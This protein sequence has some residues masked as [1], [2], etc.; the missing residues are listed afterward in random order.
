LK[1]IKEDNMRANKLVFKKVFFSKIAILGI[2]L[3]FIIGLLLYFLGM[4][5]ITT[6][7][8]DNF[9]QKTNHYIHKINNKKEN[10]ETILSSTN[11]FISL[12][13]DL[14]VKNFHSYYHELNKQNI[15]QTSALGY[16]IWVNHN[17]QE[18]IYQKM[19]ADYEKNYQ[20]NP[21]LLKKILNAIE[22]NKQKNIHKKYFM[23]YDIEPINLYYNQIG[24]EESQQSSKDILMIV[25][26][27]Y[28]HRKYN[29]YRLNMMIDLPS[30]FKE[31]V[32]KGDTNMHIDYSI[33]Q[34]F[35]GKKINDKTYEKNDLLSFDNNKIYIHFQENFKK[36]IIHIEKKLMMD[37]FFVALSFYILWLFLTTLLTFQNKVN[38]VAQKMNEELNMIAW[39]D[40]LTSLYNR[41]YL[42][43]LIR[44]KIKTKKSK[45][46]ILFIDLDGFKKINDTLGHEA[47]DQVLRDYAKKLKNN[48]KNYSN[49][50]LGRVGGDEFIVLIEHEN[51]EPVLFLPSVINKITEVTQQ[52]FYVKNNK[53]KISQSIGISFYPEHAKTEEELLRK[54]DLAMYHNKKDKVSNYVVY[55]KQL[56]NDLVEKTEIESE[57]MGALEKNEIF[58]VMQPKMKIVNNKDMVVSGFEILLRWKNDKKDYISPEKFIKIAEENGFIYELTYWMIEK[59]CKIIQELKEEDYKLHFSINLSAQQFLNEELAFNII[60]IILK[61]N[62]SPKQI[63]FEITERTLMKN[64]EL[65]VSIMNQFIQNG[66]QFSIDDFGIGY[67][68]LSYL[69]KLPVSELKIDKSFIWSAQNNRNSIAVIKTIIAMGHQLRLKVVAEGVETHEQFTFLRQQDCDE[70]QGFYFSK[71]LNCQEFKE[72]L[73]N[74]KIEKNKSLLE[75][76]KK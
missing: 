44:L 65:S 57:L 73:K 72:F 13:N 5:K 30:F 7:I 12:I 18:F 53:F 55:S 68:S 40:N 24:A 34:E 19:M 25:N 29:I 71:P 54:S 64:P 46:S 41:A 22:K 31:I 15:I 66:F 45:F 14:N 27:Q 4:I 76:L 23:V 26:K 39:Y 21:I 20:D 74:H 43:K 28:I 60:K 56:E 63:L 62:I 2:F 61:N 70:Y 49:I 10:I 33:N 50:Y 48:F 52:P 1:N 69:T 75:L 42:L 35:N 6:D 36:L 32:E 3:S 51:E 38:S 47:G 17:N 59:T 11:L 58:L 8:K 9:F 16:S 37:S 67:S